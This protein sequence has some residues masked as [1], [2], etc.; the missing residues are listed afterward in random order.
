M[1]ACGALAVVDM[2]LNLLMAGWTVVSR[3]VSLEAPPF[4]A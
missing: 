2:A 3:S 4:S 1:A